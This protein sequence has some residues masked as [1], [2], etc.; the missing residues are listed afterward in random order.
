MD[1][2]A[3]VLNEDVGVV[4]PGQTAVVKVNSFP[5]TRFGTIGAEVLSLAY[6]AIPGDAESR[7]MADAT[8]HG[9]RTVQAQSP[10]A[11]PM[12]YLVYETRLKL[13]MPRPS[14]SMDVLCLW[15]RA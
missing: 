12:T 5:F 1:V 3:Y 10:T 15:C 13:H 11:K 14:R 4:Q 8:H 2:Q 7:A 9:D 6:D